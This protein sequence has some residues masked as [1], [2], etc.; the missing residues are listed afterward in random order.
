MTGWSRFSTFRLEPGWPSSEARIAKAVNQADGDIGLGTHPRRLG[1]R[2]GRPL[3]GKQ[4]A[5]AVLTRNK[6]VV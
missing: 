5:E 2:F 1:L 3:H 6:A 4:D